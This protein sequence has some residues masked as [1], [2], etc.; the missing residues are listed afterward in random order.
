M[1]IV[2]RSNAYVDLL[3]QT[4]T[5]F[6]KRKEDLYDTLNVSR[7]ANAK[8]IKM[9]YFRM[10]KQYHP[11]LNPDDPKATEKFQQIAHAY[12]I[13]SD[14]KKR[15]TYDATGNQEEH[16]YGGG[17]TSGAQQQA[18]A[19]DIFRTAMEDMDIVLDAFSSYTGEIGEE[20]ADAID[21]VK[22]RD[23]KGL[24]EIADANKGT[25]GN[26]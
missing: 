21:C 26:S 12:E 18:H 15:R 7:T 9:A 2:Q 8:E 17:H 13:L 4:R 19:E 24:Y 20:M 5:I 10:A 16:T 25:Y 23:W 1:S 11:D 6:N 3:G 22:T 14:E